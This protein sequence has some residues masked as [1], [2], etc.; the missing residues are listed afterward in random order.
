MNYSYLFLYS[1]FGS[2]ERNGWNAFFK[3]CSIHCPLWKFCDKDWSARRGWPYHFILPYA[4][5]PKSEQN[6]PFHSLIEDKLHFYSHFLKTQI[7]NNRNNRKGLLLFS[8]SSF[9]Y[10]LLTPLESERE[11]ENKKPYSFRKLL[12]TPGVQWHGA[13]SSHIHGRPHYEFN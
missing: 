6:N 9:F 11:K 8:F 7:Q 4:F 13:P 2:G 5:P 1:L 10:K 3:V 12:A